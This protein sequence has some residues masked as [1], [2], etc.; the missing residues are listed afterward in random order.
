M[1]NTNNHMIKAWQQGIAVSDAES[2]NQFF[3]YYYPRLVRFAIQFVHA[4]E[5]AEEMV[6][7]SMVKVWEKR[8]TILE[9]QNLE[10]YVFVMVKNACL[11]HNEKYSVVHL[12]LDA[13]GNMELF[14][15]SGNVQR[16]LEMKELVHRL[17]MAVEQLPEQCRIIFKMVKED[18]L[19]FQ[20]V[21]DILGISV[22]TV[23]T[24]VYRAVKKLKKVLLDSPS[25]SLSSN[26]LLLLA[27]AFLWMVQ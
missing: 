5:A 11:N 26:D 14:D 9:V 3:R 8:S 20:E 18:G 16:Q 2:F 15:N 17:H 24:Q 10:V 19:K 7:D 12:Q 25:T 4:R 21:A 22:R 27:G 6:S 23:E 13:D 1:G